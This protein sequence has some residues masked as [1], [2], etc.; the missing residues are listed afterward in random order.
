MEPEVRASKATLGI[1]QIPSLETGFREAGNR[2]REYPC[3]IGEDPSVSIKDRA[4]TADEEA[5]R[6]EKNGGAEPTMNK[7]ASVSKATKRKT[8]PRG[9]DAS[10]AERG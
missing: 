6:A 2:K 3:G 1:P 5:R 4:R 7:M 10:G 8:G 9:N